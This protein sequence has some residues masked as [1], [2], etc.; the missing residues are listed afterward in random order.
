[1]IG[2]RCDEELALPYQPFAEAL[3]FQSELDDVPTAW[4]GP[5]AGEL[6]RLVPDLGER[7]PGSHAAPVRDD[8]RVRARVACSRP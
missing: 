4:L 3:R 2:G 7:V 1:M 5:L 8:R 6:Q